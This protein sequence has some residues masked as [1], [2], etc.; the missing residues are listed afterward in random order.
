M[1]SSSSLAE[2]SFLLPLDGGN[3]P[4]ISLA[5]VCSLWT[6]HGSYWRTLL[7][8]SPCSLFLGHESDRPL[9][10]STFNYILETSDWAGADDPFTIMMLQYL[11][12]LWISVAPV[13]SSTPQA[14]ITQN[15]LQSHDYLPFLKRTL[16]I[17]LQAHCHIGSFKSLVWLL[18]HTVLFLV[19][20]PPSWMLP[21]WSQL[22]IAFLP[23]PQSNS[24]H[25]V[26]SFPRD[27]SPL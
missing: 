19:V 2:Q 12:S 1:S 25:L 18:P 21:L 16:L 4:S 26:L 6:G 14:R 20:A 15:E 5:F 13:A 10:D 3:S 23:Q 22:I 11:C 17:P 27:H 24:A 7:R 9:L 8:T